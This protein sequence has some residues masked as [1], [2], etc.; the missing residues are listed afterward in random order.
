MLPELHV[1]QAGMVQVIGSSA[2]RLRPA[3]LN[4]VALVSNMCRMTDRQFPP[5]LMRAKL[6]ATK[7]FS[8]R[9]G[10]NI[11]GSRRTRKVTPGLLRRRHE[12]TYAD[13]EAVQTFI[14][15]VLMLPRVCR[16]LTIRLQVPV[17]VGQLCAML[18]APYMGPLTM[19]AMNL[20]EVTLEVIL[21]KEPL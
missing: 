6:R 2:L 20:V 4:R 9:C 3:S 16:Q 14:P 8:D 18:A 11:T 10:S 7:N 21:L 1:M 19:V 17:D 12:E 15:V 13:L 5:V